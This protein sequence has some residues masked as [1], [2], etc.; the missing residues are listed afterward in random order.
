MYSRVSKCGNA[1]H[2]GRLAQEIVDLTEREDGEASSS[3]WTWRLG[4]GCRGKLHAYSMAKIPVRGV[5]GK[6]RPSSRV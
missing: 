4:C 3:L 1:L 6:M 2:A 5:L